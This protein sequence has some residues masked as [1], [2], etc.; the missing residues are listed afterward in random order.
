[1]SDLYS[2]CRQDIKKFFIYYIVEILSISIPTGIV[3]KC[4]WNIEENGIMNEDGLSNGMFNMGLTSMFVAVLQHYIVLLVLYSNFDVP[5]LLFFLVAFQFVW[6][7]TFL[8][9]AFKR[10]FYYK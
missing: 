9:N 3:N 7:T 2:Y 10:S 5:F 1:M 6:T 4:L 8:D